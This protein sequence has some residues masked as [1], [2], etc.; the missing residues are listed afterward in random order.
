LPLS[1]RNKLARN[2]KDS[3]KQMLAINKKL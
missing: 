3:K 2:R 1:G